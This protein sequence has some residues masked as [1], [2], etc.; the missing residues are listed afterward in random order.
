MNIKKSPKKRDLHGDK[1]EIEIGEKALMRDDFTKALELEQTGFWTV[2]KFE[3]TVSFLG[4]K[5]LL[6]VA[7]GRNNTNKRVKLEVIWTGPLNK[8]TLA[9][10]PLSHYAI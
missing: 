4:L 3:W 10:S 8:Q 1:W 5:S 9:P 6:I 7:F 2:F